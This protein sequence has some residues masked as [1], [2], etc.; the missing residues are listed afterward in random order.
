MPCL[1]VQ[2]LGPAIGYLKSDLILQL[3]I[4]SSLSIIILQYKSSLN[5]NMQFKEY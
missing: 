4:S 1:K 5:L 3:K 2:C